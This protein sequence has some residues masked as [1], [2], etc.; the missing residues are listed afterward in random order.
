M[1]YY[2]QGTDPTKAGR[3][4]GGVYM[5]KKP[6]VQRPWQC[7][8]EEY[9]RQGEAGK[10]EKS[11][12]WKTAI[13]LQDVDGLETSGYLLSTAKEHIEG[14]IDISTACRRIDKKNGRFMGKL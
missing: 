13:G 6:A 2:L 8:L 3:S 4:K 7:D 11:Y 12:A 10:A 1:L 9:T 14:R 5:D